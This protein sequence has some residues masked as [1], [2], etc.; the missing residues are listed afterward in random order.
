[1]TSEQVI[2]FFQRHPF[3]PFTFCLADG[4]ELHVRHP[5]L[6]TLGRSALVIYFFHPTR[7]VEV[8][9]TALIVSIRT[10]HA[11]DIDILADDEAPDTRDEGE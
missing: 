1:M 7:Q 2:Y 4:R 9:D 11:A 8:V 6:G 3:V 5:E 10:I